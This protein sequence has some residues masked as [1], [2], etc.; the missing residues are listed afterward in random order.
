MDASGDVRCG[1]GAPYT[2]E[3][4]DPNRDAGLELP[5]SSNKLADHAAIEHEALAVRLRSLITL[6]FGELLVSDHLKKFLTRLCRAVAHDRRWASVV[7]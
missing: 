7:N 1:L 4:I 3:L 6:A 2:L 5:P